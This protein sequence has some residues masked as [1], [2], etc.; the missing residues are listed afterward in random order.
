MNIKG[1][2]SQPGPVTRNIF[3]FDDVIMEFRDGYVGKNT[4]MQKFTFLCLRLEFNDTIAPAPMIHPWRL[5]VYVNEPY[6]SA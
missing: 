5:W 6:G 4:P 2:P 3:P 1:H